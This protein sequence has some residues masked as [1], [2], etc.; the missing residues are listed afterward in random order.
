MLSSIEKKKSLPGTWF[1]QLDNTV[2]YVF[3]CHFCSALL[4]HDWFNV[5]KN[6]K[7]SSPL[8]Q[9]KQKQICACVLEISCWLWAFRTHLPQ[10]S[11]CWPYSLWHRPAV[12]Q[13]CC[14]DERYWRT[15]FFFNSLFPFVLKK[16]FSISYFCCGLANEAY[17]CEELH[18]IHP[19][20]FE[21]CFQ[22]TRSALN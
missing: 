20:I 13:N 17:T 10:L 2:K 12:Q 15:F 5:T 1:I 19:S 18:W 3:Y 7:F 22:N 4:C 9:G 16:A 21:R 14:L 11:T 6:I 8:S